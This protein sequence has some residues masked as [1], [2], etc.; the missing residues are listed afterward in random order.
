VRLLR[1]AALTAFALPIVSA[2]GG[3]PAAAT[4]PPASATPAAQASGPDV[5]ALLTTQ[6][7]DTV[8][9]KA[10][11]SGVHLSRGLCSWDGIQNTAVV[12]GPGDKLIGELQETDM[13][14]IKSTYGTGGKDE[15]VSG[16]AAFF[17]PTEGVASLWVDVGDGQVL[18]LTFPQ[19]GELDSSYER[20]LIE[21]A[22]KAVAKL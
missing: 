8:T 7:L 22:E 14:T 16:D 17:N 20:A 21:L 13:A 5:C 18:V 3:V 2:C 15:T 4:L 1:L 9:R 11:Q 6:D 12:G 19:S 10:Y